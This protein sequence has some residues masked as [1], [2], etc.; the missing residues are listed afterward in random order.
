MKIQ[1]RGATNIGLIRK[2]NEDSIFYDEGSGISVVCDGIGGREGGEI[3]SQLTT[4]NMKVEFAAWQNKKENPAH[5]LKAAAQKINTMIISK[6]SENPKLEGM[7]TTMEC[8]LY[9][10]GHLY[11][12]HIGDSRTYL[13]FKEQLWLLT[14]DHNVKTLAHYGDIPSEITKFASGDSLVKALGVAPYADLEVYQMKLEP[15]QIFLSA[16]DGLFDM[17]DDKR[18]AEIMKEHASNT[19]SMLEALVE[20]AHRGG[21]VDNISVV[22]THIA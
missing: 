20:S 2:N 17:I 18:I 15:G 11:L 6:G 19:P 5:F 10:A 7:G 16:S 13:Y 22:V 3:A 4:D 9:H 8:A 14:V 1:M 12:G 21:G